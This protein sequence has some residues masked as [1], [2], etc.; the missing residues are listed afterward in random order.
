MKALN[1]PETG[2]ILALA[3]VI[4][5]LPLFLPNSFYY[6]VVILVGINAIVCV[7][8]NLL[9]G[10]AGQI[11][12]GH[13][14]FFALG[15]YFSGILVSQHG[16]PPVVAMLSGAVFVGVLAY[17]LARPVMKLS[18]HYLAMGTL[19]MGI[20]ISIVLN[21]EDELTGGPDGMP[22]AS[23]S[24]FGWHPANELTWYWMIGGLLLIAVWLALNLINSPVGRALRAVHGSEVAASVAG[25]DVAR[26]KALV[27]VVSAVFASIAGSLFAH[28]SGFLTP[29]EANFF[30]SIEL[31]TMV[32]LGGMASIF[33]AVVGAA[34]L[35]MLPQLLTVFHDY[36]MLVFGAAMMI[37]MIFMRRGLVPTLHS[38][39]RR[40]R[41]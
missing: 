29:S 4:A 36:E 21:Q 30:H 5:V 9:I 26:Y 2:G 13:A 27:F 34:V 8:L 23:F 32:V 40:W 15:A 39:Y 33:G 12:L 17:I 1:K 25:V 18:G 10:Y 6:D 19:G 38:A 31:V 41:Q 28:Y 22:I 37:T 3:L 16:W 7:G 11:S 20:V 35:T 14:G 24:V